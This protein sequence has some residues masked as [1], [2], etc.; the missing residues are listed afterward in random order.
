MG[1]VWLRAFHQS[2]KLV[3][4]VTDDGGGIDGQKLLAKAIEKGVIKPGTVMSE[5]DAVNLIFHPGFSSKSVVS[6]VSGRGVGMDVVKTNIAQLQG[7]VSVTTEV[8][9]GTTLRVELPLTLAIIDGMVVENK[10]GLKTERFVVPLS[11]VYESLKPK[12]GELHVKTG[13]GEV[14]QLR[15]EVL[16]I[17]RLSKLL[18]KPNKNA[19]TE[20]IALIFRNHERPYAVMVDDILRQQQIVVKQLGAELKS[21]K[22]F[23]GTAIL[24]D[25]KPA[26]ILEMLELVGMVKNQE[27]GIA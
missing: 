14:L 20:Q 6:E 23:S 18:S 27:R 16:P 3:L 21:S 15:G 12:P 22:G 24:G 25:G 13:M 8:G 1:K 4:E 19:P 9:K 26:L 2:G 5:R 11:H 10:M 17:Y 7:E